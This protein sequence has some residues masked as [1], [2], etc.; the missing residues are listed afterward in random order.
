MKTHNIKVGYT[1]SPPPPAGF[2]HKTEDLTPGLVDQKEKVFAIYHGD[3]SGLGYKYGL[4][5]GAPIQ[6]VLRT[7][8]E[9]KKRKGRHFMFRCSNRVQPKW[10]LVGG[11]G[12]H[13]LDDSLLFAFFDPQSPSCCCSKLSGVQTFYMQGEFSRI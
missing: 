13:N 12:C 8:V 1:P 2:L 10:E 4:P 5:F 9:G 3:H 11:W 7:N 6:P